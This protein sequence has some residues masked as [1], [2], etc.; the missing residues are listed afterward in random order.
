[1]PLFKASAERKKARQEARALRKADR[2][3]GKTDRTKIRQENRL[4]RRQERDGSGWKALT[5]LGSNA[6]TT[7]GAS[8]NSPWLTFPNEESSP[9]PFE[10]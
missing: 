2:I 8:Q 5:E 10:F 4:L 7:F 3:A 6:I 1:M 9:P